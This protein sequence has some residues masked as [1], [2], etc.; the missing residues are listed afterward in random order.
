[1]LLKIVSENRT[2]DFSKLQ[3]EWFVDY[4]RNLYDFIYN[5]LRE[6]NKLPAVKVVEETF[7]NVFIAEL[8][9]PIKFYYDRLTERIV[10]NRIQSGLPQVNRY[11]SE[12]NGLKTYEE[13]KRIIEDTDISSI[14][15]NKDVLNIKEL[16][17]LV[18]KDII[19]NRGAFTGVPTGWKTLDEATGGL[20]KGDVFL[21]LA[22]VKMGKTA[23][24]I[25]ML[26]AAI[27]NGEI[28]MLISMEMNARQI[29]ARLFA[30]RGNLNMT[31]LQRRTV[32]D[33]GL[34]KLQAV[35]TEIEDRP[36]Y[37]V[38]GQFKT[39]ID[40]I[41]SMMISYKPTVVYLDGGYL[42]KDN[43]HKNKQK[44]EKIGDVIE[45]L[46]TAIAQLDIPLVASYQFNRDVKR[47]T[48]SLKGE[49]FESIQLSDAISQ[50]AS[51][52]IA[53]LN[54]DESIEPTRII[55]IIGGRGGEAGSFKI[56]WNWDTMDFSEKK[57]YRYDENTI[58]W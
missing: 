37:Y 15:Y 53:I 18:L 14:L 4:E 42:V 27:D 34:R 24:L 51:T 54:D 41:V 38:E 55:E 7:E 45:R 16:G 44:W 50:I 49:A 26:N 58:S 47:K 56:N 12:G 32:S 36:F 29:G 20:Q 46:K 13:L 57:D 39:D 31:H 5:H 17:D 21:V 25:H 28:P 35:I 1:M 43:T 2:V 30:M 48:K 9:E 40:S 10:L 8:E 3:R 11:I 22:R 19:E 6:Y 52:G 33:F 23:A